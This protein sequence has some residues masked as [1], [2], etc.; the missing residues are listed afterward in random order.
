MSAFVVF[1]R[2][3]DA[4]GN[5]LSVALT[6]QIHVFDRWPRAALEDELAL[7]WYPLPF[8]VK[9]I[10]RPGSRHPNDH[11]LKGR[12][13]EPFPFLEKEEIFRVA[14]CFFSGSLVEF[15]RSCYKKVSCSLDRTMRS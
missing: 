14:V 4:K 8:Q 6:G 2:A 9:D 7:G 12:S 15:D 3:V 5:A 11:L 1:G 10:D 13:G